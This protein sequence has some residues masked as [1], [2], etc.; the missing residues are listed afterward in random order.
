MD[1]DVKQKLVEY[2]QYFEEIRK[3]VFF[4]AIA[5][6]LFFAAGFF[7]T[8]RILG[9]VIS[10]FKIKDITI[11]TTSP[12]QFIS[13]AVDTGIAIALLFCLPL[14]IYFFYDFI[15]DGLMKRERRFFLALIPIGMLLF[16]I[17]FTYGFVTLYFALKIIAQ[18]N[19][20]LGV[21]NL[22]DI[23]KFLSEIVMTSAFL[24]FLFEFPIVITFLIRTNIVS[25]RFLIE[26]RRHAYAAIMILVSLLPPTD[27]VSL[28]VMSVPLVLI[29]EI[30]IIVNAFHKRPAV[31]LAS[32]SV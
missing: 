17:G 16:V 12:F 28:I 19:V 20:S 2:G 25:R 9:L 18:V 29:Y 10:L 4:L 15:K 22:W 8:N 14:A 13:L 32:A 23:S 31:A 7:F 11:V 24:G 27:G 26:K 5:F 3:K 30:T 6:V 21:V 1:E